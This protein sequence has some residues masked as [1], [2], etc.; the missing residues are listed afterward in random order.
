MLYLPNTEKC[1]AG[2]HGHARPA[3]AARPGQHSLWMVYV[4]G[5]TEGLGRPAGSVC[6][7]GPPEG[8]GPPADYVL[9]PSQP[10]TNI[11][12]TVLSMSTQ[13]FSLRPSS[14]NSL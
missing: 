7:C 4:C 10:R 12:Q 8:L 5:P 1:A 9:N 13:T 3:A 14:S 2:T 11:A 6:V